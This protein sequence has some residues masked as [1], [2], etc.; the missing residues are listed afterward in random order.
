MIHTLVEPYLRFPRTPSPAFPT[1]AY[2][3]RPALTTFIEYQGKS[4]QQT[5][6][7]IIDSGA[8]NCIF[9]AKFGQLVGIN[10]T[11]GP[12]EGSRGIGSGTTYYH[13]VRVWVMVGGKFYHFNCYAG[14]MVE[15]DQTGVGF[16]GRRGFFNLFQSITFDPSNSLVEFKVNI[17]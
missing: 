1:L 12:T 4:P 11:S 13:N 14:F 7:S 3:E 17:P 2:T 8:D 15:L 9:P 16:L 5:F 6:F 10:I